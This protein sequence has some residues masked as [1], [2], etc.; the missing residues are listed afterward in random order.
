MDLDAGPA[1]VG[2]GAGE[3]ALRLAE[4]VVGRHVGAEGEPDAGREGDLA[5]VDEER[6]VEHA[7]QAV[8]QGAQAV[9]VLDVLGDDEELVGAE[10]DGGV[11]D[12]GA[13]A[14]PVGDL[15]EQQVAGLV[16][17]GSR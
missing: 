8:G 12:P 6:L 14:Q 15:A 4:Q 3:R 5:V 13:P 2:L 7:E 17:R 9:E 1:A 10:A 16:A 11:L